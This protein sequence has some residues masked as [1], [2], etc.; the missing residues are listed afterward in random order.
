MQLVTQ[1]LLLVPI[2]RK[3]KQD[4]FTHF[5][6]EVTRYM[7]PKPATDI[8]ETEAWID[9]SIKKYENQEEI[10]FAAILKETK[11]FIGCM[12]MDKDVR[13]WTWVWHRRDEEHH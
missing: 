13:T 5:N 3:F 9:S 7:Y 6:H 4:V 12:G 2:S 1:R 11:E 8:S 10:V